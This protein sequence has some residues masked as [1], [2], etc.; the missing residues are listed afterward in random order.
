VGLLF[1]AFVLLPLADLWLLIRIGGVIGG[2]NVLTFTLS[3]GLLGALLVRTQGRRVLGEFRQAQAQGRVPEEGVVGGLLVLAG[4]L[5]LITPGVITDVLGFFCL[6]PPTRRA[7]GRALAQGFARKVAQGQVHMQVQGF[8]FVS[9]PDPRTSGFTQ[10]GPAR[11]PHDPRARSMPRPE[12]VI[13]TDGE[14]L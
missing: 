3:M 11:V 9:R 12:D 4:G 1:L 13:D 7:I 2:L 8:G 5:L 14:E 6:F 10:A